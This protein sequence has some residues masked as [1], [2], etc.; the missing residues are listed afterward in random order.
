MHTGDVEDHGGS[1]GKSPQLVW[2]SPALSLARVT[3][4]D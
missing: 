4:V 3:F 1:A 2:T